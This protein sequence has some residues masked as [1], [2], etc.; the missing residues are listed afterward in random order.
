MIEIGSIEE[1]VVNW[2]CNG[3]MPVCSVDDVDD[4]WEC[5]HCR[6]V[7]FAVRVTSNGLTSPV[8]L[9]LSC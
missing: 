5:S 1:C 6:S 7:N 9:V 8:D 3:V 4:S 2:S